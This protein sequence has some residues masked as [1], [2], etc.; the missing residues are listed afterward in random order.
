MASPPATATP[1]TERRRRY[2][3]VAQAALDLG[4]V[5][6]QSGGDTAASGDECFGPPNQRGIAELLEAFAPLAH[7]AA[8]GLGAACSGR[9]LGAACSGRGHRILLSGTNLI[10]VHASGF[11]R[12]SSCAMETL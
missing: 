4:Q 8:R 7:R 6:N 3:S 12:N 5:Q 10:T 9:G 11:E 1:D 2:A